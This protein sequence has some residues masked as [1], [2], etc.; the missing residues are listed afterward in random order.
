MI[1]QNRNNKRKIQET[2]ENFPLWSSFYLTNLMPD[3]SAIYHFCRTVDDI[4]D[5]K[6]NIAIK[7]LKD[8]KSDLDECFNKNCN[9]NDRLF[10]LM[11]TIIKF[12]LSKKPFENLIKANDMDIKYNRYETY[13]DL[14]NYCKLSANPVGEIVLQIFGHNSPKNINFSNEICT[15]LKI[16]L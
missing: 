6:K 8:L 4:G 3:L 13:N 15:G 5:M 16:C 2:Y 12:N 7:Q 1:I 10:P 14:V 9:R 11:N